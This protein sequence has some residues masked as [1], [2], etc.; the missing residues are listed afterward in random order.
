MP[1]DYFSKNMEALLEHNPRLAEEIKNYKKD[2]N[3]INSIKIENSASGHPTMIREG[4]YVHSK[5][6]P[7]KEAERIAIALGSQD[8]IEKTGD[9]AA[10]I[11]LGF[12]L[13]YTALAL[14]DKF[15]Q[16]P[17]IIIEKHISV[18]YSA[19]EVM[20]LTSFISRKLLIF[21]VGGTGDEIKTAL[22]Y[23]ESSFLDSSSSPV[24]VIH[25]RTLCTLD[26][27]WYENVENQAKSHENRNSINSATQKRFGK[28]WVR[29]LS[30]NLTAIRDIPGIS[31]LENIINKKDIPVFLAAAGP[32]LDLIEPYIAE[33]H[34]RCII[35]AVDTSLRF[36][37]KSG[38]SPDFTVS[39]DPQYWNYRH[40]DRTMAASSILISESAVYPPSLRHNFG[41][42]LLSG[43]FFPLGR[44]M[45]SK[46]DPKGELGAGG[47]VATS[48]WD[49]CRILGTNE[50]W[51][52]GLD[53]SFPQLKTHFRGALFEEKSHAETH[54]FSPVEGWNFKVLRDGYPFLAKNQAGRQV[55]T[56]K[57]L[58]LYASWFENKFAL[59]P[60]IKN[61]CLS[62]EGLAI[63]GMETSSLENLLSLPSRRSEIDSILGDRLKNINIDFRS[64]ANAETRAENFYNAKS[65][66]MEGL[67]EIKKH[68]LDAA[69]SAEKARA[70]AKNQSF[71][72]N[73]R[74]KILTKL[75]NAN[76]EILNSS[77]KEI[78]GFLF[79]ET[80]DWEA[81]I[82]K[83]EANIFNR[84][85]IF[86]ARFYRALFEATEYTLKN[87]MENPAAIN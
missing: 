73:S 27:E 34:K 52:A 36:I 30:K 80:D 24:L 71:D 13:G 20:D 41:G 43:S 55:L 53:L 5:Q 79:P 19:L 61:Y 6:N 37:L 18:L 25:N 74:A 85:L 63:T 28:R 65:K 16:R 70:R 75:D 69:E 86:S 59:Y 57:R 66:L 3:A 45:E 15:P 67:N 38:I 32:T 33:I 72:E 60:S 58:S 81:E 7:Q 23:I 82:E 48:A 68:S 83:N 87:L 42:F 1:A 17:I 47:S 11:I 64:K 4:L 44:Y 77:V 14:A 56:D 31:G 46:V 12:G 84:H 76:K 26:R 50:I 35:V 39:V 40:L 8:E 10:L 51:I 29:N 49:F 62:G 54:R 9:N 78:A 2:N 22:S 21:I